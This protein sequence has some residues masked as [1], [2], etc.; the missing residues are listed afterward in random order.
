MF[1]LENHLPGLSDKAI[2]NRWM[3]VD[4]EAKTPIMTGSN[5]FDNIDLH[6]PCFIVPG[7]TTI[8][9]EHLHCV[10]EN[11]LGAFRTEHI[12]HF[13]YSLGV[14]VHS[15]KVAIPRSPFSPFI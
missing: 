15:I 7:E 10:G 14:Q 3:T 2:Q 6:G 4:D 13:G 11:V 5:V 1:L 9:T 12:H 8:P